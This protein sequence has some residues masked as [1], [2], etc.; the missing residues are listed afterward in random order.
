[1]AFKKSNTNKKDNTITCKILE[2]YGVIG[3]RNNGVQL[4]LTFTSWSGNDSDAKYDLRPWKDGK[5]FKG[6]TMTGEEL[7]AL[8]HTLKQIAESDD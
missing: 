5:G 1:M 6:V 4:K 3:E 7:E 2:D 8:Y